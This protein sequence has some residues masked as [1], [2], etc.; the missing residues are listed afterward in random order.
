MALAS[1]WASIHPMPDALSLLVSIKANTS[2]SPMTGARGSCESSRR[3][4]SRLAILPRAI[5]PRTAGWQTIWFAASRDRRFL[6]A[7]R[8]AK[9]SIQTVVSARIMTLG[10][11]DAG[12]AP[13]L[14]GRNRR[15]RPVAHARLW[16]GVRADPSRWQRSSWARG[17]RSWLWRP[18]RHQGS[19]SSACIQSYPSH[20]HMQGICLAPAGSPWR[21]CPPNPFPSGLCVLCALCGERADFPWHARC[22]CARHA[23]GI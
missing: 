4:S 12:P 8:P 15:M 18:N 6:A 14:L 20:L 2:S 9:K 10:P 7:L 23:A 22:I 17:S 19:G 13:G 21:L 16:P 5:S 1:R 11:A 3:I